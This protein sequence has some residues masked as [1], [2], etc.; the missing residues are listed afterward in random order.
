MHQT[1]EHTTE[2][3]GKLTAY[4]N[5]KGRRCT[6]ER[7]MILKACLGI[8]GHFCADDMCRILERASIHVAPATVYS[9]LPLLAE[10]GILRTL[11]LKDLPAMY[12]TDLTPHYHCVCTACGRIKNMRDTVIQR[13]IR[14]KHYRGFTPEDYELAVYGLCGACARNDEKTNQSNS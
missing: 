10:A 6:P 7:F 11:H 4:L 5:A 12:E 13:L 9:T 14:N 1:A 8:D 3:I 2:L